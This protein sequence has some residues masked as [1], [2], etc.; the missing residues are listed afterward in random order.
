MASWTWDGPAVS[1]EWVRRYLALLG[2][3][4]RAPGPD[5]L[6]ELTRAHV[7]TVRFENVTA[8][9]RRASAL[10]RPAPPVD[11]ERLL[12]S[13][14]QG[15]GGGVCFEIADAFGRLLDALGYR[16]HP[17]LG[18]I[19]FPGSHQALVVRLEGSPHLVDVANGAP[20]LAPI[21]VG[22]TVEIR[23]AGLGYRFRPHEASRDVVQ[24]RRI[25]GAWAPFCR[26]DPEPPD[27]AVREAAYQ[28]HHTRGASWVVGEIRL[29][30]CGPEE[31]VVLR[32]GELSRHTPSGK[33]V[34]RVPPADYPRLAAEVFGLPA[35]PVREALEELLGAPPSR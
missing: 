30:R 5:A 26:Y 8:V 33:R 29:I 14:E 2:V 9:L 1:R 12:A 24:E 32:D 18:T 3:P 20:F 21:P 17:T 34:E 7:H 25:D 35:L 15:R 16:V 27:P 31:V 22:S 23:H 6:A 10:G 28:R 4:R 19:T 11:P 13:W